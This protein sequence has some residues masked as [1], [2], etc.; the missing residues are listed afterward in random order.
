MTNIASWYYAITVILLIFFK[1]DHKMS[2]SRLT[3]KFQATIPQDIR[4]TLKLKAGDQI[5]FEITKDQQVIIKKASPKDIE[6]LKSLESTLTEW[7]SRND[8]EDY[9]DL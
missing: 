2:N 4:A 3:S 6:Y 1:K 9:C 8:E 7:S 5:I